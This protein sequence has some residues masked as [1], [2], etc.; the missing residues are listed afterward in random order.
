MKLNRSVQIAACIGMAYTFSSANAATFSTFTGTANLFFSSVLPSIS[1][2]IQRLPFTS[3]IT[4]QTAIPT[5]SCAD[6]KTY[7][8][9]Q[10]N[11]MRFIDLSSS[12]KISDGSS[13]TI[14]NR[15]RI[16]SSDITLDCNGA[17]IDGSA[18]SF[19]DRA[20]GI[21]ILNNSSNQETHNV[22]IK[23]CKIHQMYEGVRIG[24][25]NSV[26]SRYNQ[27]I[28][29]DDTAMLN[30]GPKRNRLENIIITESRIR[31]VFIGDHSS[32]NELV[33]SS[34]VGSK[35]MAVYLEFGSRGNRMIGNEF[36]ANGLGDSGN[37]IWPREAVSIDSS[38]Y[39]TLQDN[40]FKSNGE[41]SIFLYKNCWENAR[42][43]GNDDMPR[44]QYSNFNSILNNKFFDEKVAVWI[45][46]RQDRN[47]VNFKCGDSLIKEKSSDPSPKF[48][49]DFAR[50]NLIYG[51]LFQNSIL[52]GTSVK[53]QDNDNIIAGNQFIRSQIPIEVGTEIRPNTVRT[54]GSVRTEVRRTYIVNNVFDRSDAVGN[55]IQLKFGA[56]KFGANNVVCA[57]Q[58]KI[59]NSQYPLN[60][61]LS[62]L[63]ASCGQSVVDFLKEARAIDV[64]Q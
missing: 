18:F 28:G 64:I 62:Q 53:V 15:I 32:E 29:M 56:E 59:V 54:D 49:E 63:G 50:S 41:G 44:I 36:I 30:S 20:I 26:T 42:L 51:N 13:C 6:F 5:K 25:Y 31:G 3:P 58:S 16:Q 17:T 14:K 33:N 47:L 37:A 11:M 48:Y 8:E 55:F 12:V 60:A 61:T 34:I 19:N 35:A 57:N 46:S 23:N 7:P 9:D 39:N 4:G 2:F 27:G 10:S 43:S 21:S 24:W 22:L 38:A 45:A 40:V 1:F 52:N